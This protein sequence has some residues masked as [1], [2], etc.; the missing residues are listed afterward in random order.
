MV[1]LNGVE[2]RVT[3]ISWTTSAPKLTE[4]DWIFLNSSVEGTFQDDRLWDSFV[5]PYDPPA[6]RELMWAA[7]NLIAHPLSELTHWLGFVCPPIRRFGEWLH[8]VTVP[9]HAPNTGRG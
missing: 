6:K 5:N 9:R 2:H 8:D 4:R 7:H 1:V 3:D